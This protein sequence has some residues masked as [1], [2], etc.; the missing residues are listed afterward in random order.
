[1]EEGLREEL[2]SSC[3]EEILILLWHSGIMEKSQYPFQVTEEEVEIIQCTLGPILELSSANPDRD[4]IEFSEGEYGL[5]CFWIGI[6]IEFLLRQMLQ[7]AKIS[8]EK[9]EFMREYCHTIAT[10][11]MLPEDIGND[12]WPHPYVGIR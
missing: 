5:L 9:A 7:S 1:M 4:I 8:L 10:L 12:D 2:D 3:E 6:R 11:F